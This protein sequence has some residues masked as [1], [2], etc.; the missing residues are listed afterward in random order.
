MQRLCVV[1]KLRSEGG[2]IVSFCVNFLLLLVVW[3][4]QH[5]GKLGA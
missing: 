4:L 1:Y 5:D 3:V 2:T